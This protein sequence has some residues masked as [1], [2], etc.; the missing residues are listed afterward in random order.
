M[1]ALHDKGGC[2]SI[3][4]LVRLSRIARSVLNGAPLS[5]AAAQVLLAPDIC[6]ARP[7][8]AAELDAKDVTYQVPSFQP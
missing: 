5:G 8:P 1:G 6:R 4:E 2:Q 7:S 3:G